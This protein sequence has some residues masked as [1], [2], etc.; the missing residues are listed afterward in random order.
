MKTLAILIP[1]FNREK[2]VSDLINVLLDFFY[3]KPI[4]KNDIKVMIFD[5]NSSDN[6]LDSILSKTKTFDNFIVKKNSYNIGF[7]QNYTSL[8]LNSNSEYSWVIGDDDKISKE[9]ITEVYLFLKNKLSLLP[10]VIYMNYIIQKGNSSTFAFDTI[11]KEKQLTKLYILFTYLKNHGHFMFIS[12]TIIRNKIIVPF[13]K[14]LITFNWSIPLFV[15]IVASSQG[16][17]FFFNPKSKL[18]NNQ[19]DEPSWSSKKSLINI[20]SFINFKRLINYKPKIFFSFLLHLHT[21]KFSFYEL[22]NFILAKKSLIK[23]YFRINPLASIISLC[24]FPLM[25]FSLI[26]KKILIKVSKLL[27]LLLLLNY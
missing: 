9:L 5:N 25:Y 11:I 7:S 22:L 16:K 15:F 26:F 13:L 4:L 6:T 23:Y 19:T 18:V 24:I 12:S 14:N 10:S 3:E 27:I 21:I 20:Y 8:I 17:N 2:K 1:T